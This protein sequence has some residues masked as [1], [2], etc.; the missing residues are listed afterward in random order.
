MNEINPI[1]RRI[2][3]TGLLTVLTSI[4]YYALRAVPND[5]NIRWQIYRRRSNPTNL[6]AL[7]KLELLVVISVLILIAV[8]VIPR[9]KQT[10]S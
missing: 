3:P 9:S 7:E 6:G 2:Q 8:S 1:D 5:N 10:A 4:G